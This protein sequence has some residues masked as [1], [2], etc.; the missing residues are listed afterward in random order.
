MLLRNTKTSLK[1]HG[2][3]CSGEA[4]CDCIFQCG[5]SRHGLLCEQRLYVCV[6]GGGGVKFLVLDVLYVCLFFYTAGS[7]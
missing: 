5:L 2:L 3:P 1:F 7:Y 6:C 4:V